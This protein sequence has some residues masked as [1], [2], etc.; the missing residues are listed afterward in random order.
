[1]TLASYAPHTG[2]AAAEVAMIPNLPW[3]MGGA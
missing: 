2:K 1:M 3:Y